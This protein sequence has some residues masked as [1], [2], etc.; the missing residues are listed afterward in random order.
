MESYP[1]L[2][3]FLKILAVS[4]PVS[5]IFQRLRFPSIVGFLVTGV[6]V[7]PYGARL[8]S[9]TLAVR[10][11]A[12]I[13]VVL[14]LF[15]IGLEFSLRQLLSGSLKILS[16]TIGQIFVTTILTVGVSSLI[17]LP[18]GSAIFLGLLFSLSST[19]IVLKLLSDRAEIDAPHGRIA[20]SILLFQDLLAIPIMLVLPSFGGHS[21]DLLQVA[22][23]LLTA[24]IAVGVL[25]IA[26]NY[27]VPL[28]LKQ[29]I[30][31]RDHDVFL[32]TILFICLGTAHA[33]SHMG[34][35]LAIGAFIAGLVISE[36]VYSHQ[37][38][39]DF[40]PFRNTFNAIFF[41]SVGMLLNLPEFLQRLRFD[42][43]L[44]LLVLGIKI[45]ALMLVLLLGK[46]N[47]RISWKTAFSLAQVGEFSFL[48][49][50]HSTQFNILPENIYQSFLA[51][52]VLTM[53]A[54]PFLFLAAEPIG[55]KIQA[56][57][58]RSGS[59]KTEE[60]AAAPERKDHLII[61]GFGLNGKNLSR[62]VRD[63]GIPFVV[64]ELSDALVREAQELNI[65]VL[66]GDA[67]SKEVLHKSGAEHA[68]MAVVAISDASATR[69]CVAILHALNPDLLIAVRT[70]Y[71]AEMETLTELGANI[72]IPEEF[73]TSIEIFARVL[74][75]YQVPDHL[76]DQQ[77]AIIRSDS[78]GMLRGLSLTQERLMKFSEL[79]LKSTIAQVLVD[80]QSLAKGKSLKDL[81]L[82]HQTGATII[83]IIRADQAY[84]NP[85][86]DF[87][88]DK[89]DLLVL[90]GAHAQLAAAHQ[91][92]ETAGKR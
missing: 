54:T 78:Y 90:W 61:I 43:W 60:G 55:R 10:Q 63:I 51:S 44:T 87:M 31:I 69:R 68:K 36:S 81:D 80:E 46:F 12:D 53:F 70:R 76:I 57:F 39:S 24:F 89:D 16:I 56:L 73:E 7:G 35:S 28:L 91:L 83:A 14:L 86:A 84:S 32:L 19:A 29:I 40:L 66:F 23:Q 33:T 59:W 34:V 77:I 67:T 88:I 75:Q 41:I 79:F 3:D 5:F 27:L 8:I 6:I 72:V 64:V 85:D 37:I 47:F 62:V 45:A 9:D 18:L 65:P 71:V 13:G 17:H 25:F 38:L 1:L 74:Q 11:L 26:A 2:N 49:A 30:R 20:T 4:I 22:K 15:T 52:S 58:S 50:D 21:V 42:V 82:R 92:L 48:I